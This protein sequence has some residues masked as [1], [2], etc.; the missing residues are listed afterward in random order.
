MRKSLPVFFVA[1]IFGICH[2]IAQDVKPKPN[3]EDSAKLADA[4]GS[5]LAQEHVPKAPQTIQSPNAAGLGSYG[6]IPVSL[7]TGK[8]EININLH[9]VSDG[10]VNIPISLN[11]DASGVRPDVHPGWVGLNFNLSTN[12]AIVRT[13]RDAPDEG[14]EGIS[15]VQEG[16]IRPN[17]RNLLNYG[18]ADWVSPA[19]LKALANNSNALD[20]E[21]DEYSFTAPGLSG[22]F[23]M[24]QDGLWKIQCDEP[25]KVEYITNILI[26]TPF[27]PPHW[28][29][30]MWYTLGNYMPH[31]A[32][33]RLTDD[34]GTQYEF[35]GSNANVE[36]SMD[37]FDQ[38]KDT[39]ICNA[40]YLKSITRQ[41]GQVLNFNYER[42]DFVAQMYF[43]IYNKSARVN[44]GS[45]FSCSNWSSLMSQKGPY[46]GKLISPIYLK[47]ISGTNFKVKFTSSVSN[48]LPYNQD[49]FDPYVN[50][51]I[52]NGQSKVDFLTFLYD[53]FYHVNSAPGTCDYNTTLATLLAKLK[54][55]KLNNIEIQNGNGTTIR[56]F[57]L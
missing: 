25:V 36:Y 10:P 52:N 48:E 39:W 21:P 5:L 34:V 37:F 4:V 45:W 16:Y 9:A 18:A 8:P 14:P 35:G 24:G 19:K 57:E 15:M 20:T 47:E 38:G 6:E 29:G 7:Y 26:D 12:F 40:W 53:C 46:N 17:V 13:I 41:T 44:G 55:R 50:Y 31:L 56:E 30:N 43:S 33:F 32:G 11:Y 22:K 49:I 23:Y 3:P 1:L 27:F 28:T 54:W 42:G 51:M 2:S